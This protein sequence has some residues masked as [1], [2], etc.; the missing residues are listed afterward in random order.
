MGCVGGDEWGMS[1]LGL[2]GCVGRMIGRMIG[3]LDGGLIIRFILAG[4]R[5]TR[6][7]ARKSSTIIFYNHLS[8]HIYMHI[9]LNLQNKTKQNNKNTKLS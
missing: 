5:F 7:V 1:G 6:T 9:L 2:W 4:G 3:S 8:I